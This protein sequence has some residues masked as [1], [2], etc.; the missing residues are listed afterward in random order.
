MFVRWLCDVITTNCSTT[1]QILQ[2]R[3][4]SV[5]LDANDNAIFTSVRV[6]DEGKPTLAGAVGVMAHSSKSVIKDW[7]V[8]AAGSA[9]ATGN[10]RVYNIGAA[11]R[12][13]T[14]TSAGSSP[15]RPTNK[16]KPESTRKSSNSSGGGRKPMSLAELMSNKHN[17]SGGSGQTEAKEPS[18]VPQPQAIGSVGSPGQPEA[19]A[20]FAADLFPEDRRIVEQRQYVG[21]DPPHIVAQVGTLHCTST[22]LATPCLT[23]ASRASN[24]V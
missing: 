17:S 16:P 15:P 7:S 18:N 14:A 5:S 10:K 24:A 1:K 13:G 3:G 21:D 6:L 23:R 20:R 19:G 8:T 22:P 12:S 4:S 2:V 11:A 9:A